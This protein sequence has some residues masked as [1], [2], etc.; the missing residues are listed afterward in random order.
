MISSSIINKGKSIVE[1]TSLSPFEE[2]YN[3]IQST[4]YPTIKYHLL[5]ASY[6]YHLPYWLEN[7]PSL[8]Y[9]SQTLPTDESITEVMSLEQMP[10]KGHHH[11]T[12]FL[13]PFHV[14]EDNFA[15]V[16]SYDV[17]MDPQ[18]PILTRDVKS[19]GNLWNIT[20]TMLIDISVKPSIS[21]YI[22][23]G[24]NSSHFKVQLYTT[25]FKEFCDVFT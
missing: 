25:L 20:K 8:Y 17:V 9:L 18:S 3:A 7:R 24:H 5:V 6:F 22:Q 4:S 10:W 16:V 19:E 11:W 13:P 1:S 23:I 15:T 2:V 21:N 12:S 14:L